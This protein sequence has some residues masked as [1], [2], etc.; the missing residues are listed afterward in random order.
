[1]CLVFVEFMVY[2]VNINLFGIVFMF[3]EFL[4]IGGGFFYVYFVVVRLYSYVGLFVNFI[5]V[6]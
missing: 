5:F 6:C 2:N 1:M 3:V 4:L